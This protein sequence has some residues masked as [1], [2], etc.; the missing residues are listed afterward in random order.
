MCYNFKEICENFPVSQEDQGKYVPSY[1][2]GS[3]P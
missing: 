1:H 2:G 3:I